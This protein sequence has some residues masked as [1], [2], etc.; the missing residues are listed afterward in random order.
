MLNESQIGS[1]RTV[2]DET[3]AD[4]LRFVISGDSNLGYVGPLGLDFYVMS[5]AA[6]EDADF[7]VYFGDTIYADSGILPTGNAETLD[8]YREVHRLTREDPQSGSR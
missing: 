2:P 5:A 8:E 4:S 3:S 7:F 1:F 6:Q